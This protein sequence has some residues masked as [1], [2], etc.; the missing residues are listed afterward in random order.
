MAGVGAEELRFPDVEVSVSL[1]SDVRL[2]DGFVSTKIQDKVTGK[3]IY[4]LQG[5][6]ERSDMKGD[7]FGFGSGQ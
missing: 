4:V 6:V 5:K 3:D 2:A 1:V 7:L